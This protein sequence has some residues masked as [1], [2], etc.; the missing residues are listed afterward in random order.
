MYKHVSATTHSPFTPHI[1][2][3]EK[4]NGLHYTL[5]PVME[6]HTDDI[7]EKGEVP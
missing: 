3:V 2:C 1:R 7:H 4:K 5:H 6:L